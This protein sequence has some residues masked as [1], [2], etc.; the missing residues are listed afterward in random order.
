MNR[1]RCFIHSVCCIVVGISL[2]TPVSQTSAGAAAAG[3]D[4]LVQSNTAFALDL[5]L[6]TSSEGQN[7]FFSPFSIS[8]ALGMT[9]AGARGRT[10]EEMAN[11][12]RFPKVDDLHSLLGSLTTRITKIGTEGKVMLSTANSLWCQQ[13]YPFVDDF[14][15]TARRDYRAE[16]QPVNFAA[17]AEPA[18]RKINKWVAE[19]THDKIEELLQPGQI[20]SSTRLVL[21]NAVYFKGKWLKQFNPK[22]TATRPFQVSPSRQVD[23]PMMSQTVRLRSHQ[24]NE[25]LL[26]SLPYAGNSVSMIVLLPNSVDG[27]ATLEKSLSAEALQ[28]WLS[29]LAG[30]P[31][32]ETDL[33]LPRFKLKSRLELNEPLAALGMKQAFTAQADFT[34]ISTRAGLAI[35]DVVHEA[36]VDVNEE[37]TEAAAATGVTMRATSVARKKVIRVDHPFIFL[38]RED[39]SGS[40]LFLGKVVDPS[41]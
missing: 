4:A 40:L 1:A 30:S 37:G 22:A 26:F 32:M 23:T 24:V 8:T 11:A 12:L 34:G 13:D 10:A 27:L 41:R 29:G 9:Y 18:R 16:A 7:L 31:E 35:D 3:V 25:V 14:L 6:R 19:Q 33:T 28:G 17:Q 38:I 36:V 39:T 20:S 2:L 5:Y 15:K 21:C